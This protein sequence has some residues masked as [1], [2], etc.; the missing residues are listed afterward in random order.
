MRVTG[1]QGPAKPEY[2]PETSRTRS[3][4]EEA[5][6]HRRAMGDARTRAACG[7]VRGRPP[8]W[9]KRQ[10]MDRIRWRVRTWAPKLT[11]DTV[12]LRARGT[13]PWPTPYQRFRRWSRTERLLP[14][15]PAPRTRRD[16]GL[17]RPERVNR[18]H[19]APVRVYTRHGSPPSTSEMATGALPCHET[20]SR[21]RQ[22]AKQPCAR[23]CL[24]RLKVKQGPGSPTS[25]ASLAGPCWHGTWM[26]PSTA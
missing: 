5:P 22:A 26:R 11:I 2:R 12:A 16:L 25:T 10:I 23:G 7:V 6:S 4:G 1:V 20:R 19:T 9:T 8:R 18:R 15:D 14:L 21:V 24:H 17:L 3:G 13:A